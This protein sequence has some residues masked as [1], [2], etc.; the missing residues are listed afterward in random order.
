MDSS[1]INPLQEIPYTS[2]LYEISEYKHNPLQ[3]RNSFILRYLLDNFEIY[4]SVYVFEELYY[5]LYHKGYIWA[6]GFKFSILLPLNFFNDRTR[7]KYI[8]DDDIDYDFISRRM[9]KCN[10]LPEYA[11][12][13]IKSLKEI[14]SNNLNNYIQFVYNL[15][16]EQYSLF[17]VLN[18]LNINIELSWDNMY[19]IVSSFKN[20]CI[21]K[22][23]RLF[24][25]IYDD[26]LVFLN[27]SS[28]Q[29]F[30]RIVFE[31][32][33][34]RIGDLSKYNELFNEVP[35][36]FQRVNSAKPTI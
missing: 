10:K 15:D 27:N 26:E 17:N 21:K 34:D 19:L 18:D 24:R 2:L 16:D 20:V 9:H 22:Y 31:E 33:G 23:R 32:H 28:K 14:P 36:S 7:I 4:T 8:T 6:T 29:E 35:D 1:S 12:D 30:K 11:E 13:S 3:N 25:R 5:H